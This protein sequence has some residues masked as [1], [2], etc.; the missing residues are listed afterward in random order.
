MQEQ[1]FN[2]VVPV[3]LSNN[4][5]DICFALSAPA[6][7]NYNLPLSARGI[8]SLSEQDR[9]AILD[10]NFISISGTH[11]LYF[12]EWIKSNPIESI[13]VISVLFH[14]N[15]QRHYCHCQARVKAANMQKAVAK[16]E[17][18]ESG[19]KVNFFPV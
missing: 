1:M 14:S 5:I 11:R 6:D 18:R 16:A 10:H 8:N 13:L 2:N 19:K 7:P 15:H 4:R 17:A 12:W 3:T 9:E